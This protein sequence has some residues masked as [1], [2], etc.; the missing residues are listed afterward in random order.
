M[1]NRIE[2]RRIS[3]VDLARILEVAIDDLVLVQNAVRL[4]VV[5]IGGK[6][7]CENE[8]INAYRTA[9]RQLFGEN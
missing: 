3:F 5:N 4:P 1:D 2:L 7:F 9:T 8:D 6:L